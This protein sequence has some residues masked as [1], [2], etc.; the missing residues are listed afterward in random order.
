[1]LLTFLRAKE[2]DLSEIHIKN[3]PKRKPVVAIKYAGREKE[4]INV[5][6]KEINN[7]MKEGF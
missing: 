7:F 4:F 3:A 6:T 5:L 1:M 2:T